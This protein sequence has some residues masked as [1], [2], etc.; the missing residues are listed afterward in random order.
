MCRLAI[1]IAMLSS[2]LNRNEAESDFSTVNGY[3]RVSSDTS[4][5]NDNLDPV[6]TGSRTDQCQMQSNNNNNAKK[7]KSILLNLKSGR[8]NSVAIPEEFV[9]FSRR[10]SNSTASVRRR[11]IIC[12][13]AGALI[14]FILGLIFGSSFESKPCDEGEFKAL[15]YSVAQTNPI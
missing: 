11:W 12:L 3:N 15:C 2:H 4:V 5:P 13:V 8:I 14:F 1:L 7:K 9:G 10:F 6:Y